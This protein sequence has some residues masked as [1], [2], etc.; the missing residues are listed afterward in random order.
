MAV[1]LGK[2]KRRTITEPKPSSHQSDSEDEQDARALFQRAFEAKF[3]PLDKPSKPAAEEEIEEPED[4]SEDE[5]DWSGLSGDENEDQEEVETIEYAQPSIDDIFSGGKKKFM[6]S[7]P[8]TLGEE[9][10]A[11]QKHSSKAPPDEEEGAESTNLKNDLAL[12][13]L[14]KE[15][16]I[17][18]PSSFRTSS[19]LEG[20][21]RLKALDSRFKDLGAKSSFLEQERMPLSHRKGIAAKSSAREASRRK[22]AAENG[23]ILERVKFKASGEKRRERSVG[24]PGIGKFRGGT[25]KLSSRDVSSIQ[26]SG[27]RRGG[28]RSGR[29]G[30]RGKR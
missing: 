7:K 21:H 27:P 4:D 5:E 8:P 2:R 14:L 20:K 16:H 12:Q 26:N 24:G 9:D 23:V 11:Q 25:L 3:R 28:G 6:S 29:G 15:S 1:A 19:A 22:E 10:K 18:D 30:K 13:R 17:L